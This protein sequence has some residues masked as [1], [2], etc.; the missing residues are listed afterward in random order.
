MP[1]QQDSLVRFLSVV[2]HRSLHC[3]ASFFTV[4]RRGNDD[5]FRE[6]ESSERSRMSTSVR[7]ESHFTWRASTNRE[8]NHTSRLV[9]DDPHHLSFDMVRSYFT[10]SPS[11]DDLIFLVSLCVIVCLSRNRLSD[12]EHACST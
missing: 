1:K 3:V 7:P 11:Y 5:S 9:G 8:N 4:P 10:C 2:Y 12:K 6:S